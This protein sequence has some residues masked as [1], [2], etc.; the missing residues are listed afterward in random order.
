MDTGRVTPY[1]IVISR[2]R[3]GI[4]S[5]QRNHALRNAATAS[6]L[7]VLMMLELGW[8]S[9]PH[10]ITSLSN[11]AP[12]INIDSINNVART[13]DMISQVVILIL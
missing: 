5:A 9:A 8:P 6:Y 2:R 7:S 4:S 3:N 10:L 12:V 1:L 13:Q 11:V